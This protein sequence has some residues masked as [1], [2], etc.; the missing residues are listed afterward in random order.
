MKTAE[1]M[2][3]DSVDGQHPPRKVQLKYAYVYVRIAFYFPKNKKVH[4]QQIR[5]RYIDG[6]QSVPVI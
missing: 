4:E 5:Q 1:K 2:D 6:F 3:V